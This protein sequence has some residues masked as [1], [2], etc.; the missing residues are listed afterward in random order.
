MTLRAPFAMNRPET[1]LVVSIGKNAPVM[2]QQDWYL[3]LVSVYNAV[4]QGLPQS[5]EPLTV[6]A[7]PFT[8]QAILKGQ[9]L[10]TGGTVSGIEFSRDG[11]TYYSTGQISGFIQMDRS[12]Y[13][14][15]T[16]TV[17]PVVKFFPM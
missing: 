16:Y 5:E 7:S 11:T 15:V 14:R 10:I 12:D 17:T 9:V 2:I 3:F 8:Y 6:G 4:T 1:P 13:V